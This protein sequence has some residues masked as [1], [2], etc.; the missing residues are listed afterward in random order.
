MPTYSLLRFRT[1]KPITLL[2]FQWFEHSTPSIILKGDCF[3]HL[4]T[5]ICTNLN[6]RRHYICR[7]YMLTDFNFWVNAH[8][9]MYIDQNISVVFYLIS[10]ARVFMSCCNNLNSNWLK[11]QTCTSVSFDAKVNFSNGNIIAQMRWN[12]YLN[13][14]IKSFYLLHNG[15]I[16]PNSYSK[17]YCWIFMTKYN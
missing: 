11:W 8:I 4:M 3:E 12:V 6:I 16:F 9:M 15:N 1:L 14:H 2:K 7:S 10:K 5:F 17:P 13:R